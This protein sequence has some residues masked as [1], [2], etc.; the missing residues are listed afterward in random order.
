ML[1]RK[2]GGRGRWLK[3]GG[4]MRKAVLRRACEGGLESHSAAARRCRPVRCV[5]KAAWFHIA[6]ASACMQDARWK[7]RQCREACPWQAFGTI[8]HCPEGTQSGGPLDEQVLA[9]YQ[10]FMLPYGR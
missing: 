8:Q 5:R 9:Q 2:G 3:S 6:E 1:L 7:S 4:G 10:L